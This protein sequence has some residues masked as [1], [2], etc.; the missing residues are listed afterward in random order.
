[1]VMVCAPDRF[2]ICASLQ[3]SESER[4]RVQERLM[5]LLSHQPAE[6]VSA[7]ARGRTP[8]WR[9]RFRENILNVGR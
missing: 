6:T 1:M 7:A 4:R 5:A 8:W 3:A 2:A 9:R